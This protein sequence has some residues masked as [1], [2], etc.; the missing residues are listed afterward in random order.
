MQILMLFLLAMNDAGFRQLN[1]NL[2]KCLY[3]L[4]HAILDRD[5]RV[6]PPRNDRAG[7]EDAGHCEK[8]SDVA[9]SSTLISC[10]YWFFCRLSG[11]KS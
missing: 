1:R 7:G 6:V 4:A 9:I 3:N 2:P 10:F 11:V 5:Y 8:R